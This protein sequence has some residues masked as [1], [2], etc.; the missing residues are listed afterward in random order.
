MKF[1][2]D[3]VRGEYAGSRPNALSRRA[4]FLAELAALWKAALKKDDATLGIGDGFTRAGVQ[5]MLQGFRA[6]AQDRAGPNFMGLA[7]LG[8]GISV[9]FYIAFSY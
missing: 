8:V 4:R 3:S 1:T 2:L 7:S 9:I 5:Y 6:G